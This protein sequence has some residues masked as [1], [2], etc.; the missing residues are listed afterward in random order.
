MTTVD[1]KVKP[2][3]PWQLS[4]KE[5]SLN[6]AVF[7]AAI[8]LTPVLL[9]VTPLNGKL[10]AAFIIFVLATVGNIL[11]S[12][13]RQGIRTISTAISASLIYVAT[14][15]VL[16]P[17]GSILFTVIMKGKDS[18]KSNTFLKD[19]RITQPDAPFTEG[20]ALHAILGT[21]SL[22]LIATIICVPIGIL[23]ALY[24]TEIKGQI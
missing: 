18:I 1:F 15:L 13:M 6:V 9:K 23:T 16:L 24:L 3:K 11:L 8:L 2:Q 20:G 22:V 12:V 4:P 19:M 17:L 5:I 14:A 7:A 10:G 21:T